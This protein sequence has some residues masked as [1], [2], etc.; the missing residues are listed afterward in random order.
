VESH[1]PILA[2]LAEKAPVLLGILLVGYLLLIALAA[3]V[4]TL[5]P[6]ESRR[7]DAQKVLKRLLGIARRNRPG[8]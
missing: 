2:A 4:G 8:Q 1:T 7:A 6:D 5:H 3:I